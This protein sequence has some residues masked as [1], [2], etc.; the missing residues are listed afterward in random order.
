MYPFLVEFV[1]TTVFTYI[2]L[3]SKNAIIIGA[4]LALILIVSAGG[5]RGGVN[6]AILIAQVS[7]GNVSTRDLLPYLFSQIMGALTAVE[8]Y[9]RYPKLNF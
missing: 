3:A 5:S 9:N 7:A 8:L 6:P 4:T 2:A 1:G